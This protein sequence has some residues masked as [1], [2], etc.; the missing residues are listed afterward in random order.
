MDFV[1]TWDPLAACCH[2]W[3]DVHTFCDISQVGASSVDVEKNVCR[4]K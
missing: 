1:P 4:Q 2:C 3:P